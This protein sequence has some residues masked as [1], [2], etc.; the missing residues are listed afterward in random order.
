MTKNWLW[1]VCST[2]APGIITLLIN[3]EL[4]CMNSWD[5]HR[6]QEKTPVSHIGNSSEFPFL[7]QTEAHAHPG[8]RI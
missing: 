6:V 3:V 7:V 4:P 5:R 8:N 1:Y 2:H